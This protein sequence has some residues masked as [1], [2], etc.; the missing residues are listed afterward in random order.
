ML[1]Q[2]SAGS[3]AENEAHHAARNCLTTLD[4]S[5][6]NRESSEHWSSTFLSEL[7]PI[8]NNCP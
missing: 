8:L 2:L 3:Q 5:H 6:L 1:P 4:G 7:T